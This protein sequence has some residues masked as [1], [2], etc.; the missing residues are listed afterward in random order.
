MTRKHDHWS[1]YG[2]PI[3][4]D[5]HGQ[6]VCATQAEEDKLL[7]EL[8]EAERNGLLT[9]GA[10]PTPTPHNPDNPPF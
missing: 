5:D 4:W 2:R 3:L 1:Y 8:A 6:P 9:S 10:S 7:D